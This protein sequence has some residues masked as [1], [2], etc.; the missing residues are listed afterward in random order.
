MKLNIP[1][2]Y[3]DFRH[4]LSQ[5]ENGFWNPFCLKWTPTSASRPDT[6]TVDCDGG[7]AI[8]RSKPQMPYFWTADGCT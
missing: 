7:I 1:I 8:Y 5:E 3:S 2:Y 4:T 6:V